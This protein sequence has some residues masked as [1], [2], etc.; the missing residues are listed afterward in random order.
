MTAFGLQERDLLKGD[1][2]V[3]RMKDEDTDS[4]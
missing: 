1:V 3:L 4:S 2:L